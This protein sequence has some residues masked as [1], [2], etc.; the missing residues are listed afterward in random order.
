LRHI[1]DVV[2]SHE[3]ANL[4]VMNNEMALELTSYKIKKKR[5]GIV[6]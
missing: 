4:A 1:F 3:L 2:E 5:K 6:W